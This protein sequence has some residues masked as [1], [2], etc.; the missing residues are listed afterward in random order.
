[1]EWTETI[2]LMMQSSQLGRE[3]KDR[4]VDVYHAVYEDDLKR[5]H[6]EAPI[7]QVFIDK[8]SFATS[9]KTQMVTWFRG[10]TPGV[11]I[12]MHPNGEGDGFPL[13]DYL[14]VIIDADNKVGEQ[15]SATFIHPDGTHT[16]DTAFGDVIVTDDGAV[17]IGSA[18]D[19]PDWALDDGA[20]IVVGNRDGD[21]E[22]A[23]P[24][25]AWETL[26]PGSHGTIEVRGGS[27]DMTISDIPRE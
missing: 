11:P 16:A 21:V 27:S 1:M 3:L 8:D 10:Q 13:N 18:V 12:R 9:H 5:I 26:A 23:F 25:E 24:I 20:E 7:D 6:N 14:D 4:G 17:R 15:C 22:T 19:L 2:L